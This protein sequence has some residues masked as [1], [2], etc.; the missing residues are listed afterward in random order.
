MS[1]ED[2][3]P[4]IKPDLGLDFVDLIIFAQEGTTMTFKVKKTAL[5]RRVFDKYCEKKGVVKGSL[6]FLHDGFN[7]NGSETANMDMFT[8]EDDGSIH[9]TAEVQQDGGAIC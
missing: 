7:L 6:R 1:N 3:K 4:D 9:V 5:L 2:V 8:Q